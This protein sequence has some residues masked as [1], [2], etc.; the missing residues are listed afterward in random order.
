[1]EQLSAVSLENGTSG[2]EL[3]FQKPVASPKEF[4]KSLT[5][6]TSG[7]GTTSKTLHNSPDSEKVEDPKDER[8]ETPDELAAA[9]F[10]TGF[11]TAV[12]EQAPAKEVLQLTEVELVDMNISKSQDTTMTTAGGSAEGVDF[13]ENETMSMQLT[14]DAK[15]G[16]AAERQD[17]TEQQATS[18]KDEV[19]GTE[20]KQ[21]VLSKESQMTKTPQAS[22]E[23]GKNPIEHVESTVGQTV[24]AKDEKDTKTNKEMQAILTAATQTSVNKTESQMTETFLPTGRFLTASWQAEKNTPGE[25]TGL[26]TPMQD[27][28]NLAAE[29]ELEAGQP[30][31]AGFSL[32]DSHIDTDISQ[33]LLTQS[34]D[35]VDEEPKAVNNSETKIHD[36]PL[37]NGMLNGMQQK[38][39]EPTGVERQQT[40][41]MVKEVLTEL[42]ETV[43]SGS[44]RSSAEVSISPERMGTIR[45]KLEMTDNV[46]STKILVDSLKV[47]E[48]LNG[49]IQQLT[50]NLNRQQIQLGEVSIQLNNNG[51]MG[52][53]FAERQAQEQRKQRPR[54]MGTVT[55]GETALL[56]A[57]ENTVMQPGRLSILV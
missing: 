53:N 36:S 46:L 2:N 29:P 21:S 22:L 28:Q 49:S 19:A 31:K 1:M 35:F 44:H 9:L 12:Q 18:M 30:S 45:I 56:K 43:K 48:L 14:A 6:A 7:K 16:I 24:H 34:T 57:E 26:E 39:A 27:L 11:L 47:H 25:A 17:N 54:Q 55:V 10:F 33:I 40:V 3:P 41:Q 50:D 51:E 4:Q 32:N 52:F 38:V 13:F 37:F 20:L 5:A 42:T 8:Q 23:G 15:S